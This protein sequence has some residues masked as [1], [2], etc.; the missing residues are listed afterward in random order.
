LIA[1]LT[2]SD[3]YSHPI[4]FNAGTAS[5]R[6]YNVRLAEG[7]EQLVKSNPD[8]SGKGIDNG[9]VEYS[10][11]EYSNTSRDLYTNA[12][13]VHGGTGWI[14]RTTCSKYPRPVRPASRDRQS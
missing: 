11:L 1:N 10:V 14:I 4:I 6:V 9:L 8:A 13:D 3:F 12:V 5:P 7:G 2:I